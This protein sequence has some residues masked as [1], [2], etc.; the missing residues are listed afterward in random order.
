LRKN[1]FKTGIL[2][3]TK[4]AFTA[5][6]EIKAFH[7]TLKIKQYMITTPAFQK[8][9]KESYTKKLKISIVVKVCKLLNINRRSEK[10]L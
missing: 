10:E 1:I 9:L 3:P 5:E 6:G 7:D 2:Y 8:T 4:L